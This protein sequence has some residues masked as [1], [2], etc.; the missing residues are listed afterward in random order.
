MFVNMKT[1]LLLMLAFA[2]TVAEDEDAESEIVEIPDKP[3]GITSPLD[4][5]DPEM[6]GFE[7]ITGNFLRKIKKMSLQHPRN[8]NFFY[9]IQLT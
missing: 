2:Y 5:C 8:S 7:L 4:D 9:K 1:V 3:A 6:I